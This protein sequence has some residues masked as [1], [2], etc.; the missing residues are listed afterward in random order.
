M[1]Q[2]TIGSQKQRTKLDLNT[3]TMFSIYPYIT[4]VVTILIAMVGFM[5]YN[6]GTWA[7]EDEN[8]CSVSMQGPEWEPIRFM[9][10]FIILLDTI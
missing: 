4:L 9:Q 6:A 8:S 2:V 7:Q 3:T 1:H 10:P 5:F